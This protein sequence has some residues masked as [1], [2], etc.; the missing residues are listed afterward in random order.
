MATWMVPDDWLSDGE[1]GTPRAICLRFV[2]RI[3]SFA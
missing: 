1:S 2:R 3:N